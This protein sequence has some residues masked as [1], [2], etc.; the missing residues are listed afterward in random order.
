[1]RKF[2]HH[3]VFFINSIV[4]LGLVSSLISPFI[5]PN[6]FWP[7]SFFGL[8]FPVIVLSIFLL[9]IFWFFSN[10]KFLWINLVILLITT[11]FLSRYFAVNPETLTD[12]GINIMSYNVR[13]FNKWNWIDV[14]N[15]DEKIIDFVNE[16]KVDVFCIQE[17]YNPRADLNFN[18]E[19][20]HIGLQKST[21]DWHMAIYSNYPQIN[22]S[23]VSIDGERMNNTCIFSD[24]I[25]KDD[26]I[27]VYNIHLASNFFNRK[28]FNNLISPKTE[29]VK[30]GILG[31]SKKL[32]YSFS[33]RGKEVEK[34]KKHMN[35]SP[36][37]IIICGDFND[38]PVSYAYR[39][40]SE[41]KKDAFI[42]SG[43]GIGATFTKIPSLRIDYIFYD[44]KFNSS[45]FNTH[46]E[47]LSDH[48]AISSKIILD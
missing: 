3:I 29:K 37:P 43:N 8:F 4:L 13:Q 9:S 46:Q 33:R 41:N 19:Y 48:R 22:K 35:N 12:E 20:S 25:I 10:K 23:T 40:L 38:T 36:Y 21:K 24:I 27:R 11:P 45:Q 44:E 34:I 2:L 32:K 15:V 28:D 31:I 6:T 42:E 7:I 5:N 14:K 26:T 39:E 18:F 30:D 47:E 17:Y 16:E 1:M